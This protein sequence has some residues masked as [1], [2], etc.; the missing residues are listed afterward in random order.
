MSKILSFPLVREPLIPY[1]FAKQHK[2]LPL[3]QE[4]RELLVAAADLSNFDAFEELR[5][6][7]KKP[8]RPIY[9]STA[10]IDQAIEECYRHREEEARSF[11]SETE[12]SSDIATEQNYDLLERAEQNHVIRMVN[13][14]LMEAIQQNASDIHFEPTEEGA[15]IRYRIDGIL[16]SRHSV[17]RE[18]TPQLAARIK[19]LAKMDVSEHRLP[20]DGRIQ[21][22]HG[23]REID[24]RVSTLPV[25]HGE[26][27]VLRI[28]DKGNVL[29]GLDRIGM[30]APLLATFRSLLTAPEGLLLVTGPTGSGKTTTLYSAITD[31]EATESN[32]MTIEDPVEYKL[33]GISQMHVNARIDLTFATGLRHI[34]R[35]DPDVI[36]IGEVRDRE[37]AEIAVQASLTGH[38][39]LTT[40][41]TNDAPSAL[42]RLVEMGIEPYLLASSVL[43]VLAQRLVRTICPHC[44]IDYEPSDRE[45]QVC[46][47][48]NVK[49]LYK[50]TGCPH[51]FHTG[52]KGRQGIYEL[53][54][55]SSAL[56]EQ[57]L[58]NQ[59]AQQLRRLALQENMRSLFAYGVSLVEEGLTTTAE[60]LR[61]R[62]SDAGYKI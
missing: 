39:V 28:L 55:M 22:R 2:V 58:R 10:E 13:M 23:G 35:Q 20:Q 4:E 26:R 53:M 38:F 44:T 32:I 12:P 16:Q 54:P 1:S 37:T 30:D 48:P 14:A 49:R 24:F 19:V 3:Q 9:F 18:F 6:L 45:R 25:V 42:T 57:I 11:F 29:V 41:H 17:S 51:C 5:L 46:G 62:G 34:L 27:I 7:L 33:A 59:D 21:L 52:Y 31:L 60:L 8:I 47:L 15:L 43:G 61:I 40:L 36:L 56:K 50:G